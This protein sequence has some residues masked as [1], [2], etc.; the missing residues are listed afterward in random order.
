MFQRN[1][2]NM[3]CRDAKGQLTS[4]A[5]TIAKPDSL[6]KEFLSAGSDQKKALYAK[7]YEEVGMLTHSSA[8]YQT[9]ALTLVYQQQLYNTYQDN[10]SD[11]SN[12]DNFSYNYE[13]VLELDYAD[14]LNLGYHFSPTDPETIL[15]DWVLAK[16]YKKDGNKKE[17]ESGKANGRTK[18]ASR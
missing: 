9:S 11:E 16:I 17:D 12:E 2:S 3:I 1:L 5:G 4:I 7:I 6:V 8:S 14:S 15:S 18:P 10:Q 13:E